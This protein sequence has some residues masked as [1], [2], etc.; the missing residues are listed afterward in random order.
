MEWSSKLSGLALDCTRLIDGHSNLIL[1]TRGHA[2]IFAAFEPAGHSVELVPRHLTSLP[3]DQ[4][5]SPPGLLDSTYEDNS[6]QLQWVVWH[7][8]MKGRFSSELL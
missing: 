3:P 5:C 7:Q 6:M 4:P 8:Q 1:V 2:G